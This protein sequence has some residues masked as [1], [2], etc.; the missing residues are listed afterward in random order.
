[1]STLL[2]LSKIDPQNRGDHSQLDVSDDGHV[3]FWREYTARKD[4]TFSETN[5]RIKNFK[6]T[7]AAK[8]ANP[9]RSHH[10]ER[11]LNLLAGEVASLII[12]TVVQHAGTIVPI[13]PSKLPGD[14]GHDDRIMRL[15]QKAC[16]NQAVDI[17]QILIHTQNAGADHEGTTRLSFT[18]RLQ[19]TS[20][21]AGLLKPT[22]KWVV[23]FDDVITNGTHYKVAKQLLASAWPGVPVT[24]VFIARRVQPP[25]DFSDFDSE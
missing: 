3:F 19:L 5:S 21:D 11:A 23:V 9:Q 24:G 6:I 4:Y 17:R 1:L 20:I 2:R 25:V 22:P 14:P 18:E 13:P 12:P 8:R 16:A 15:L 7:P 10:K